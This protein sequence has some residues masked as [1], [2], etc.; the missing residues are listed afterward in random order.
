VRL[1]DEEKMRAYW[2]MASYPSEA[3]VL[4]RLTWCISA[5]GRDKTVDMD[6]AVVM[7]SDF[8]GDIAVTFE[9]L[10]GVLL[11]AEGVLKELVRQRERDQEEEEKE[12]KCVW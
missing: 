1:I 4:G 2:F 9:E 11:G 8:D 3:E 6:T 5:I 12:S 10:T 7:S